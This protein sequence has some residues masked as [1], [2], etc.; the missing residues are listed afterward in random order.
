MYTYIYIYIR[1][2]AY[3]YIY[4]YMWRER[5]IKEYQG[6]HEGLDLVRGA[7]R[8]VGQHLDLQAPAALGHL[9]YNIR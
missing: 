5:D 6:L 7:E 4:I 9:L 8:R 3:I 1:P 2:Y